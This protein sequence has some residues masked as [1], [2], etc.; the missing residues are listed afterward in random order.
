MDGL[1]YQCQTFLSMEQWISGALIYLLSRALCE[2]EKLPGM[3]QEACCQ[4]CMWENY[5]EK[6]Q[7]NYEEEKETN[8]EEKEET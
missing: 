3:D 1:P 5:E 8:K 4:W 2:G 6:N 7:E